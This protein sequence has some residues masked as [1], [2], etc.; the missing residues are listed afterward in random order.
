MP[1]NFTGREQELQRLE[2]LCADKHRVAIKGLGGIG[3]T[4]LA[5]AYAYK[6]KH[7]YQFVHLI[8]ASPLTFTRDM[9]LLADEQGIAEGSADQRLIRL[10]HKLENYHQNY[11]LIIDGANDETSY[12]DLNKYLPSNSQCLLLTTQ[13]TQLPQTLGCEMLDLKPLKPDEAKQ[14]LLNTISSS[15]KPENALMLAKE[16]RLSTSS[17]QTCRKLYQCP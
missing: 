3:K 9:L 15:A 2:T 14:Y 17:P 5:L 11:L 8:N 4:A 16:T 10:K 1:P 13:L 6:H 7:E 12:C